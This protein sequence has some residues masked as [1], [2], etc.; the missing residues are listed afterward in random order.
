MKKNAGRWAISGLLV[1]MLLVSACAAS[2]TYLFNIRYEPSA[3][4][5]VDRSGKPITVAVYTFQDARPDRIYLGRRVYPDGMVD[6]YKPDGRSVEQIVT[7]AAMENLQK[8][9]FQIKRIEGYLDPQKEGF[10]EIPGDA[11][12]G[13][14]IETLWVEAKKSGYTTWDTDAKMRLQISWGIVKERTWITKFIEGQ[15]QEANR[16][17]FK[18]QNAEAKVNEVFKDVMDKLLKD[19][20]FLKEKLLKVD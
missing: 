18:A 19:E 6:Y 10:Q 11:V 13:G 8:A 16:P 2:K 4:V 15:A 5:M 1:G 9:G 12:L 3:P 14:K 17:F 7:R 20:S